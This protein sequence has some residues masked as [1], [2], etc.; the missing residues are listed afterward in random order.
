MVV[1]GSGPMRILASLWPTNYQTYIYQIY[2]IYMICTLT[3]CK[4][5]NYGKFI[6]VSV[7]QHF[8][9][10]ICIT[11]KGQALWRLLGIEPGGGGRLRRA[12]TLRPGMV[13]RAEGLCVSYVLRLTSY[14]LR[15]TWSYI[16]TSHTLPFSLQ[17]NST[18][19]PQSAEVTC[20][21]PHVTH[22][23]KN[24]QAEKQAGWS[25]KWR[26]RWRREG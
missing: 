23:H 18:V 25:L 11:T 22:T 13:L 8:R 21:M 6:S 9:V 7:Y 15:L 24:K 3:L 17:S 19:Q 26:W 12:C 5:T 10:V 1:L 4:E 2:D 16:H 14:V 20:H